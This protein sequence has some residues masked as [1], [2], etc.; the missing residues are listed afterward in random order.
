MPD[1]DEVPLE[2]ELCGYK[3]RQGTLEQMLQLL[4][5]HDR[6]KHPP[7]P[8]LPAQGGQPQQHVVVAATKTQKIERPVV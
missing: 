8:V 4:L 1:D 6:S 3:T 7:P 2:C 5:L